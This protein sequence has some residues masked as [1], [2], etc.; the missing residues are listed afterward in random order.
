M[1]HKKSQE[2]YDF[3]WLLEKFRNGATYR[4]EELKKKYDYD[5]RIYGWE[6]TQSTLKR[7]L[8][9]LLSY[10]GAYIHYVRR[11]HLYVFENREEFFAN[12]TKTTM[13]SAFAARITIADESAV[14]QH[15]IQMPEMKNGELLIPLLEAIR[16]KLVVKIIHKGHNKTEASER[17]VYPLGLRLFDGRWYVT[18]CELLPDGTFQFRTFGLDRILTIELTN[19]RYTFKGEFDIQQYFAN[20]YGVL[21]KPSEGF[22]DEP[23]EVVIRT[24]GV[25]PKY[26][27]D[28]PLHHSQ[29]E[30]TTE[31]KGQGADY[32]DFSLYL[33]ISKDFISE[34][35]SRME[36]LE[37]IKPE[38]LKQSLRNLHAAIEKH[39]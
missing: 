21:T 29:K 18:V 36:N 23:Q 24:F 39:L 30:L 33:V 16:K 3:I 34:L 10:V 15:Q 20:Y 1:S 12:Q 38:S 14:L 13:V 2:L 25:L 31:G 5:Q 8:D 26:L 35:Y 28:K 22:D 4:F 37:V 6:L 19:E 7:R 32:V 9:D 27:R 17:I 11:L